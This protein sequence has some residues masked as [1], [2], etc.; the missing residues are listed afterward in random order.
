MLFIVKQL[1]IYFRSFSFAIIATSLF[2]CSDKEQ[3]VK[4][5]GA[6]DVEV[7]TDEELLDLV[8]SQTFKY[9]WDFAHPM[10][11][12]AL[13][14]SNRDAY[15]VQGYEIVTSGGSGFGVMALVVG[16]ERGWVSRTQAVDRLHTITDFLLSGDRFH[17]AFPHW[18]FG[19]TGKVRPFFTEDNGG[20][21]VETSFMIQGLLTARQ[22]FKED[23]EAEIRLREKINT[24][25]SEVEWDWYTRGQDILTWHWSP[26][27]QWAINHQIKGYNEAL[28]TYVLAASSPTHSVDP[29]V[30]H[31][32][33]TSGV[34]FDN[35]QEYYG[36]WVLPLGPDFGGPLFFAHYSFLGL[37][38]RG[39][40]D[41]YADYWQQN[42][43][44]AL[45][46]RAYCIQN[47]KGFTGYGRENWG[48]TASDNHMGYSAH[49]PTNDLGVISPTAAISSLPYTPEYSM[50]AIRNFYENHREK[51]WGAYG[52]YDAFNLTENWYAENYLAIDQAPIVV[53]IENY[54]T[55][56]LWDLC[57]SCPEVA[58]GLA[59][60]GFSSPHLD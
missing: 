32:G 26:D 17:G 37:D 21:I 59:L 51:L 52:F 40:Q 56:L 55:G 38:P 42:T 8:Q 35:G 44:H 11:G 33:W 53:M 36:Q 54:R 28:I 48:L 7:L 43:N 4:E 14:R 58:T 45:I 5:D 60:L 2:M 20:D 27:Y 23:T 47:P 1:P 34:D 50:E 30:Y 29:K 13:E 41:T 19:S 39:L 24:L 6:G 9:F 18:Y 15:G 46:N 3:D 16:V 25:W 22:Y 57:M 10:S 49:S 31:D 12:M